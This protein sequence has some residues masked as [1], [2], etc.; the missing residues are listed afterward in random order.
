M[1]TSFYFSDK[2]TEMFICDR[3]KYSVTVTDIGYAAISI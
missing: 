3:L 2:N 1:Y